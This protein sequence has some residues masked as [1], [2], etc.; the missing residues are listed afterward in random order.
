MSLALFLVEELPECG[1]FTLDGP[2]GHHAAD[3]ARLRAGER[4]LL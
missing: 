3:V 4:L 2:E 1:L